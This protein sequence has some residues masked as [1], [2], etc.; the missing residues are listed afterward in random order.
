MVTLT[1]ATTVYDQYMST[2]TN[3][4]LSKQT[5]EVTE[6]VTLRLPVRGRHA[7]QLPG[8]SAENLLADITFH[9]VYPRQLLG[10]CDITGLLEKKY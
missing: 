5:G 2:S 7:K 6:G 8:L 9:C 1:K 10:I 3:L 4:P